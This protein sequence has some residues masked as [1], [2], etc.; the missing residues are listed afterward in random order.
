MCVLCSSFHIEWDA[1]LPCARP[2]D[3][4][5]TFTGARQPT[6]MDMSKHME[7]PGAA[8]AVAA[9]SAVAENMEH[10]SR[11]FIVRF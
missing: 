11:T 4:P 9:T 2:F 3:S 7:V 1:S 8:D 5:G 6:F 10:L